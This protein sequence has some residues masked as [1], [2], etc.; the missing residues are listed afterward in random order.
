MLYLK[1]KM[2]FIYKNSI[3][4]AAKKVELNISPPPF[5]MVYRQAKDE[6]TPRDE[7]YSDHHWFYKEKD[8]VRFNLV[9]TKCIHLNYNK[10]YNTNLD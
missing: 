8:H 2:E 4:C 3:V 10:R 6:M 1:V 7:I 9:Y 5:E